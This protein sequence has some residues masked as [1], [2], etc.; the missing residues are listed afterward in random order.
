MAG[1]TA[2]GF[3]HSLHYPRLLCSSQPCDN[4]NPDNRPV[5]QNF[6]K[7]DEVVSGTLQVMRLL[8]FSIT[9]ISCFYLNR[10][11]NYYQS[12]ENPKLF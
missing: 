5:L 3:T 7:T 1:E 11:L 4:Y 6:S 8:P 9:Q 10:M 2:A 12:Q